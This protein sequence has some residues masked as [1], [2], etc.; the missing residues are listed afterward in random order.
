MLFDANLI[1]DCAREAQRAWA[2][3]GIPQRSRV[4]RRLRREIAGTCESIAELVAREAGKPLLDALSGDLMVTLE[5][6]RYYERY[7]PSILRARKVSKP[8]FFFS[9]SRFETQFEPHGIALIFGPSNYPF[10]LSVVPMITALMA[11]NAVILKCSERTPATAARIADLCAGAGLPAGLVQVLHDSPEHSGALIDARPDII[12]FTGSTRHGQMI[13]ERAAKHLIPVVLELG[14]KDAALVFADCNLERAV[15]GITYGAFSNSGRVCVGVKRAYI[16]ASIFE[17]FAGQ[18][19]QR[20]STLR[21][22][23]SSDSDVCPLATE[24]R[25]VVQEQIKDAL[26]RGATLRFPHDKGKIGLE[27]TLISD[28]PETARILREECFGP[29]LCMA[30][31]VSEGEALALA[32]KSEFALSSSIWTSNRDRARRMAAGISAGSCAIN[33]VIRVIANPRAP[34]GG[35]AMSGYGRYHGPDGLRA[36]SRTKTIM[37][38][39]DRRKREINWFPFAER[40]A[41]QLACLLR[42]RHGQIG[43]LMTLIVTAISCFGVRAQQPPQTHLTVTV[44]LTHH[45]TGELAY[46]VFD[47]SSG[48]PSDP[49]KAIRHGFLPISS[50]KGAMRVETDL[51]PGKYAVSVYEDLNGNHRLDR[52]MFGIPREPVGVSNN[53]PARMGP[54][55]FNDA[56]F[57]LGAS[58]KAITITLVQP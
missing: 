49:Q 23:N 42:F 39:D 9:R 22:G 29:V 52:N 5:V 16:E 54:P 41:R 45:S 21:I 48:F 58:A 15:E 14:G 27:P 31:F 51:P 53:P 32:N 55:H 17:K 26:D 18:L 2:S 40:T 1:M 56:C 13:A 8:A 44:Q 30:P 11:G 25:S 33:D 35:N 6:L 20:I 36:F 4:L 37:T 10:Q 38:A 43:M 7:G 57:R 34:F 28:V 47:S 12:F 3:L 46:L 24:A 50:G 19:K